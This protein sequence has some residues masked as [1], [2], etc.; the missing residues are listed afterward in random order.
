MRSG[1]TL[2]SSIALIGDLIFLTILNPILLPTY[3]SDIHNLYTFNPYSPHLTKNK[4]DYIWVNADT[5]IST[6]DS[7]ILDVNP[8]IK[9]DHCIISIELLYEELFFIKTDPK[10]RKNPSH[11][12]YSYKDIKVE[13]GEW[14]WKNYN[15]DI[16]EEL[17]NTSIKLTP[18]RIHDIQ[19][20]AE[21]NQRWN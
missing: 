5:L 13:E 21:L 17:E 12:I 9:I 18:N 7:K 15:K 16:T 4:L 3:P 19:S 10:P 1:M 11:T 14:N 6:F 8:S 20:I 2:L